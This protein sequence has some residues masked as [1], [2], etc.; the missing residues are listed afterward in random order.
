MDSPGVMGTA[1]LLRAVGRE[2]RGGRLN[3]HGR[4]CVLHIAHDFCCLGLQAQRATGP[5]IALGIGQQPLQ[6]EE[7]LGILDPGRPQLPGGARGCRGVFHI[8]KQDCAV[9]VINRS[10]VPNLD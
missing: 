9:H 1:R 2:A 4:K 10:E 8:A 5:S 6:S 3:L 7:R